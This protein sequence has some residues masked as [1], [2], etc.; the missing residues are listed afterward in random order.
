MG[1][2]F[3]ASFSGIFLALFQQIYYNML[4]FN[5]ATQAMLSWPSSISGMG[6]VPNML[7]VATILFRSNPAYIWVMNIASILVP[8]F[9][10]NRQYSQYQGTFSE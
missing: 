3:A 10:S 9:R 8:G 4:G 6:V 7:T 1:T 5:F 2:I